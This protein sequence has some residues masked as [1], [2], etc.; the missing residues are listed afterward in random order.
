MMLTGKPAEDDDE[1]DLKMLAKE[2]HENNLMLKE[3]ISAVNLHFATKNQENGE[4]FLRNVF[5]NMV[6]NGFF[7]G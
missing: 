4:D 1:V 6:S 3:I 7:R 2:V 5:A